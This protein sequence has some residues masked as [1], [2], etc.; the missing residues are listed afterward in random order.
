MTTSAERR[1]L[2]PATGNGDVSNWV[3]DSRR[4]DQPQTNKQNRAYGFKYTI[5]FQDPQV[6]TWSRDQL[7]KT[8]S[9]PVLVTN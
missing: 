2:Q 7:V 8:S 3:N 9:K 1:N 5:S 6:Q 4:D